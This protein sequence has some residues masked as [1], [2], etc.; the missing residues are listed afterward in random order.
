MPASRLWP[1]ALAW[2]LVAALSLS[3]TV[4]AA[5]PAA[6]GSTAGPSAAGTGLPNAPMTAAVIST[7][8][9]FIAP[10]VVDAHTIREFCLWGLDGLGAIDPGLDIDEIAEPAAHASANAPHRLRLALRNQELA[11]FTIPGDQDVEGWTAVVVGAMNAA[12]GQSD[13]LRS[14][15]QDALLQ[16]F[17]DELFNHLDPYS[18]YVGPVPAVTDRTTRDGGAANVG[19]TLARHGDDIVVSAINADGPAWSAGIEQDQ[20]VLSV[21]GHSARNQ[22][23]QVVQQWLDGAPDSTVSLMLA[24]PGRRR[25]QTFRLHRAM[26]PPE[27]VFAFTRGHVAVLR[28]TR[29][30]TNTADEFSQYLDQTIQDPHLEGLIL[31]L[32]GDRGGVLQQAVTAAALVL[33]RGVAVVTQGRDPQANHVWAVQGGD[34]TKGAPI[35]ILV[36]GRTASAA[37]ILAAALSDHRRAVVVGSATLGKGLVQR[38][39]QMPNGGELFVTWS[40]VLAPLGWP[41]QGLGVMPQ[42][43]TARGQADLDQQLGALAHGTGPNRAAIVASRSVRYPVPVSRILEIRRNCPAAIGTDTDMDAAQDLLDHPTAYRAALAQI[44]DDL[45]P[46]RP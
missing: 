10:R 25:A 40:R 14:A 23:A 39:G 5:E 41:L 2:A 17:F 24:G 29:F 19:L 21:D 36:D 46:A 22:S 26:L 34:M 44:P 27:T 1:S 15:G 3:T 33:D 12:W 20:R 18:R 30:S 11:T 38:I 8:L 4:K 28:I 37:E 43:C 45:S 32:R 9:S 6:L 16:S 42:V 35:V 13:T 7:A 31:D